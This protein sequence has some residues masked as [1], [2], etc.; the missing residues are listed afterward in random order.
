MTAYDELV[1]RLAKAIGKTYSPQSQTWDGWLP[2]ARACLAEI[3]K[4]GVRLVPVEASEKMILAGMTEEG[5]DLAS[6]YRAM[7]PSS[8]Y[9][10]PK[11]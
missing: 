2:H 7:L 6:E 5:V 10:P 4:A 3:H 1:E 8:P 9:A 11:D